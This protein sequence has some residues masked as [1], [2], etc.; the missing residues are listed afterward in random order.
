MAGEVD[1]C[2][3]VCYFWGEGRNGEVLL[4]MYVCG[5]WAERVG[6]VGKA[7]GNQAVWVYVGVS[8][9]FMESEEMILEVFCVCE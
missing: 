1:V 8:Y 2:V 7:E 6:R 5:T 4:I 9:K 3:C